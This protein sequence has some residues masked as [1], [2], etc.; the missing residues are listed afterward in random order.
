[1][2]PLQQ[3]Q[4][5]RCP[6][7]RARPSTATPRFQY[8][9]RRAIARSGRSGQ[10]LGSP[11]ARSTLRGKS[12][13]ARDYRRRGVRAL[14]WCRCDALG[15]RCLDTHAAAPLPLRSGPEIPRSCSPAAST[16]AEA[17]NRSA[18]F[19]DVTSC[20]DTLFVCVQGTSNPSSTDPVP[21]RP[22][23]SDDAV[24]DLAAAIL[25]ASRALI[26]IAARSF[27]EISTEI[28]LQQYRALVVL[29]SRG[30][31]QAGDLAH[32]L[33]LAPSTITRLCDRLI[34]KGLVS[35]RRT[36]HSFDRRRVEIELTHAGRDLVDRVTAR[37]SAEIGHLVDAIPAGVRGDMTTALR[38]FAAAAREVPDHEWPSAWP[39]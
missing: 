17:F 10:P 20:A 27:A 21:V 3:V 12:A 31:Q 1:M 16:R 39:V 28:T 2:D 15:A 14:D 24:D 8:R 22:P 4:C 35:R 34:D 25:T 18:P 23:T 36:E 37:R 5:R 9:S 13:Y 33:D 26:A 32:A 38:S 19:H 11:V 29:A 7:S 6:E 30:P